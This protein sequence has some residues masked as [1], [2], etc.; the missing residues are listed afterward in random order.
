MRSSC[1][2]TRIQTQNSIMFRPANPIHGSL[3]ANLP[4]I[5]KDFNAIKR[6]RKA[7]ASTAGLWFVVGVLR[8]PSDHSSA[9]WLVR[10]TWIA[11]VLRSVGIISASRSRHFSVAV[12]GRG[13]G[14][15]AVRVDGSRSRSRRGRRADIGVRL[16]VRGMISTS[17]HGQQ[18]EQRDQGDDFHF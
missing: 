17:S 9:G 14:I 3:K 6:K 7:V 4:G 10:D 18:G 1:H 13:S 12:V 16:I 8:G 2:P 11:S 5:Y 15:R